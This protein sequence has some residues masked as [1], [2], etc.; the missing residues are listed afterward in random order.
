[1]TNLVMKRGLKLKA[2]NFVKNGFKEFFELFLF[3]NN[4]DFIKKFYYFSILKSYSSS[5]SNFFSINKFLDLLLPMFEFIFTFK[6]VKVDKKL[7][8]KKIENFKLV[9]SYLNKSKRL[10]YII[11]MI[12]YYAASFNNKMSI[13]L[14]YS[15]NNTFFLLKNSF[16]YKQK[17][18]FYQK[19][20][21]S[22]LN[23]ENKLLF[24]K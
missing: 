3:C 17:L 11:K 5:W 15:L 20:L 14:F 24:K 13:N 1:M 9:F 8:K 16:I 2:L 12:F 6:C 22:N 23:N 4:K 21:T 10:F 19:I 7:S 18:K